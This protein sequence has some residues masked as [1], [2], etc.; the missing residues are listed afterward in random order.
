MKMQRALFVSRRKTV[1]NNLTRFLTDGTF[2]DA[3]LEAARIDPQARAETLSVEQLLQLSDKLND[4]ILN[5][6]V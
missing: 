6:R 1:K 4:V 5:G 3:A 2:A